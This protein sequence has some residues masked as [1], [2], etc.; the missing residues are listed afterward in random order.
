MVAVPP[1]TPSARAMPK[2]STLTWPSASTMFAGLMSRCTSP[3]A[4]ATSSASHTAAA[5]PTASPA[6]SIPASSRTWRRVRPA[7]SSITRNGV[8]PSTPESNTVTSRG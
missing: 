7:T 8:V 3:A 4:C 1:A 5:M 2:S 6:A